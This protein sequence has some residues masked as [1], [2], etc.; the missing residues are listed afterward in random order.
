MTFS[1]NSGGKVPDQITLTGRK[2]MAGVITTIVATAIISG[3][4]GYVGTAIRLS[5]M[6]SKINQLDTFRHSVETRHAGEDNSKI[7]AAI[8]RQT[9]LD[10]LEVLQV[11][12]LLVLSKIGV[13]ASEISVFPKRSITRSGYDNGNG[14]KQ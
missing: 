3:F 7:D 9:I 1:V 2:I 4:S 14:N 10:R 8:E 12:Q 13:K 11:N 5:E 6:E